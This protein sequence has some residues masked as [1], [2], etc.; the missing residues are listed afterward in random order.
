MADTDVR[1]RPAPGLWPWVVGLLVLALVA[2]GA[3]ELL[4]RRAV[5]P[6]DAAAP[7]T[8]AP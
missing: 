2:W 4:D 1:R 8:G 3:V 5:A 7:A 6:P